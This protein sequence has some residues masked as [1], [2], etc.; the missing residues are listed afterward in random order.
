MAVTVGRVKVISDV[1][2]FAQHLRACAGKVQ[3][4]LRPWTS[5]IP[6]SMSGSK[7]LQPL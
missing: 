7:L 5:S 4:R 3:P 2:L 6:P 1:R